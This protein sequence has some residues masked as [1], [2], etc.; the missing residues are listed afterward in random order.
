MTTVTFYQRNRES[1]H[2]TVRYS[3]F[4]VDGHSGYAP[5]GEDILCAA[6]SAVCCLVE[7]TVN[8]ALMAKADILVEEGYISLK[9]PETLDERQ[10]IAC[11]AVLSGMFLYLSHL[12]TEY[13][14]FL[15]IL[16]K[17]I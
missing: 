7:A 1:Q 11:Q 10:H 5:E 16:E 2:E 6:L 3:G 9:L 4:E 15:R 8:D 13:A 12:S 14:Q 17:T